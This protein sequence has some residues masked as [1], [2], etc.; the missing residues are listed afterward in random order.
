MGVG[1][2]RAGAPVTG[3]TAANGTDNSL[4]DPRIIL[5]DPGLRPCIVANGTGNGNNIRVKCNTELTGTVSDDF[6][7]DSDDTGPGFFSVS[8]GETIDVSIGGRIAVHSVSFVT[9]AG[10][11]DLDDVS[12][13]GWAP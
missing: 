8:D 12:V 13:V 1:S 6:D 4:T 10:G 2:V 9:L 5:F 3:T 11:D 7:N